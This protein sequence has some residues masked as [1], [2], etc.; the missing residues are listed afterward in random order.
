MF[1]KVVPQ[2]FDNDKNEWTLL[3]QDRGFENN[4]LV[5]VHFLDFTPLNDPSEADH[6]FE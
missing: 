4:I 5:D 2:Q 3:T 1:E 6:L